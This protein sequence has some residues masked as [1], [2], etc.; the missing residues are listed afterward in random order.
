MRVS[1]RSV[2]LTLALVAAA[3][4]LVAADP[5]YVGTWKLNPAR[6]SF[7]ETTVTY[8]EIAGGQMKVTAEGLSY[9]FKAD[10]KE[11]PTPWGSSTA[12]KAVDASTWEVTYKA[13]AK[14]VGTATLKLAADGKTLTVDGKNIKATGETSSDVAVYERLSGGPGLAGKWKTKNVKIGSPGTMSIAPNGPDGLTLTFVEE[15]GICSAKFDGKDHPATGPIWPSGWMCAIAKNG[16]NALDVT[17]KRDGKVMFKD[18]LTPSAD[19]KVLTDVGGSPATTE[20]TT[21]VY[22][23]Q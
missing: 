2:V 9:T 15:K 22:D 10:G 1:V 5:P 8:E 4:F 21:A 11:Y 13:N 17:W 18:T 16:P 7:G 19:G 12:W 6:S 14:L 20:K 3:T 23:R